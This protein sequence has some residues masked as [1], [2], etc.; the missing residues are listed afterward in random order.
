ML[1]FLNTIS[2]LLSLIP[3]RL[4]L[5]LGRLFGLI[6][7]FIGIR[8]DVAKINLKIAF[9]QYSVHK[10]KSILINCYK[11]F[12]MIAFDFLSQGSIDSNNFENYYSFN[13]KL[14]GKLKNA[15]GGCILTAHIGNWEAIGPFLGL[16]NI[17]IDIVMKE[18]TNSAVNQFYEKIRNYSS[19]NLVWKK[20][21]VNSLYKALKENRLQSA[22]LEGKK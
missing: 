12:G 13:K 18:Q 14:L 15:N 5:L 11:H 16:S 9:P 7:Y 6:I 4:C 17:N 1:L 2:S 20:K 22:N 19:V 8:R 10:R 21:S 3:R